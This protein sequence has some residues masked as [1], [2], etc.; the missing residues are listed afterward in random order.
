MTQTERV[1]SLAKFK[2]NVVDILLTTDVGSRGLDIP[3]V[4]LVMNYDIPACATDYI[5]R[6]GRTARAG[7]GGMALSVVCERDVDLILN[8][9]SKIKKTLLKYDDIKDDDVC[10][11]EFL[12]EVNVSKREA[13]MVRCSYCLPT[14]AL[15]KLH[16]SH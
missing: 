1:A 6:V 3:K 11:L 4:K 8:I 10:K 16:K 13:L 2:S 9:E 5:H 14:F 12:N 7:K 15:A